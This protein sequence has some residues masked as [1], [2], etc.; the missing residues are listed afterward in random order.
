MTGTANRGGRGGEECTASRGVF[1]AGT[2][3]RILCWGGHAGKLDYPRTRVAAEG[4]FVERHTH[5]FPPGA[6]SQ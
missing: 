1:G 2:R 3:S 6:I 5:G 4:I